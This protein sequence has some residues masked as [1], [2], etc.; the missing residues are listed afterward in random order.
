MISKIK[1]IFEGYFSWVKYY[2][3]ESY[4]EEIKVEA[5]RRIKICESC[6]YFWK[7]ARN[8]M[9]CGCIMDVKVKVKFK[10]DEN[11][12]SINGCKEKKW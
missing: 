11:G 9:L 2:F 8:C 4:R 3:S 10:L 5:E 7:P 1:Q 6:E 12:I